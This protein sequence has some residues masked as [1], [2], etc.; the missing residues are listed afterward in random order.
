[1]AVCMDMQQ[2]LHCEL[3]TPEPRRERVYPG[4]FTNSVLKPLHCWN[5]RTGYCEMELSRVTFSDGYRRW[6]GRHSSSNCACGGVWVLGNKIIILLGD[7][8]II[9]Y[10]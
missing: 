8:P 7:V 2:H 5:G 4:S 6:T 1:M 10:F 9:V 3:T